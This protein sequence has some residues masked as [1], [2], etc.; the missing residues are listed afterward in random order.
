MTYYESVF[1][2]RQDVSSAH[3]E[4]LTNQFAEVVVALG[5]KIKKR[6]YWGLRTLA[7]KVNKNRKGH[8]VLFN[9]DASFKAVNEMERLMRL[10]EDVLRYMTIKIKRL[11]ENPSIMMCA[12]S[13][14]DRS[15]G[16]RREREYFS[17]RD[18]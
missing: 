2:A 11:E 12:K 4:H 1:I 3:V 17:K 9:L 14:R 7:Y 15:R 8:Y 16:E 6:E 13:N 18:T 10:N 5:G